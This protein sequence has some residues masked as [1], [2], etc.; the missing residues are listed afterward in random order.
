[1][2]KSLGRQIEIAK[3]EAVQFQ[4]V[5]MQEEANK[6]ATQNANFNTKMRGMNKTE[7]NLSLLMSPNA[8][9][10]AAQLD[11]GSIEVLTKI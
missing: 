8:K 7:D 3:S 6:N 2:S 4:K 9:G 11:L 5:A 10:G 1:M